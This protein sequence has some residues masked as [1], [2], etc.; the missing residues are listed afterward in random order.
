MNLL[1]AVGPRLLGLSVPHLLKTFHK[2]KSQPTGQSPREVRNK[3]LMPP[4][5]NAGHP[6]WF[7]VRLPAVPDQARG[8]IDELIVKTVIPLLATPN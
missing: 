6:T 7:R 3:S 8:G 4:R 1:K 2:W 5:W